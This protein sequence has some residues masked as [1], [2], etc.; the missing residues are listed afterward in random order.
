MYESLEISFVQGMDITAPKL[1]MQRSTPLPKIW[2]SKCRFVTAEKNHTAVSLGWSSFKVKPKKWT[3]EHSRLWGDLNWKTPGG[4]LKPISAPR[5]WKTHQFLMCSHQPG[6]RKMETFCPFARVEKK[7]PPTQQHPRC[8]CQSWAITGYFFGAPQSRE[9]GFFQRFT[10]RN[11]VAPAGWECT[12][13][14]PGIRWATQSLLETWS[15]FWA[16]RRWE[17]GSSGATTSNLSL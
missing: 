14:V 8:Q 1:A 2:L 7:Q 10:R 16:G 12:G 11:D 3:K 9:Q 6:H 15:F 4:N 5:F 17:L 13:F